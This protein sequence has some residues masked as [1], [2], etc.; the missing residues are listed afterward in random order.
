MRDLREFLE[1][2]DKDIKRCESILRENNYIEIVIALE[3]L[4]DKYKT[5]IEG[6]D[7]GID[8]GRVWNYSKKDLENLKDRL[9]RYRNDNIAELMFSSVRRYLDKSTVLDSKKKEVQNILDE[10]EDIYNE[11]NSKEEK[12]EKLKKYLLWVSNQDVKIATK[13]ISIINIMIQIEY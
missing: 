4:V 11:K 13:I 8:R 2:L 9:I 5:S 10:I 3:E 6:I 12:W 1:I 7:I